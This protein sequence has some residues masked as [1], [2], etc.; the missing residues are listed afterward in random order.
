MFLSMNVSGIIQ[1]TLVHLLQL[2][3]RGVTDLEQVHVLKIDH[4]IV[5]SKGGWLIVRFTPVLTLSLYDTECTYMDLSLLQKS[6]RAP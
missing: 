6:N 4:V 3:Y 2:Q 1:L 5:P